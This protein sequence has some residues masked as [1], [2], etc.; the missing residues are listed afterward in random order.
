[1]S[2]PENYLRRSHVPVKD[3]A[4]VAAMDPL[5][6]QLRLDL[7]AARAGLTC[8]A[9]VH[10]LDHAPGLFRLGAQP[11]E[12]AAP[13]GVVHGLREKAPR[14]ALDVQPFNVNP[15]VVCYELASDGESRE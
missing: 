12:E 13:R 1:M 14:K 6:Q 4:A 10:F 7:A 15:P 2:Q 9:R 3:A 5:R 8:S 11:T